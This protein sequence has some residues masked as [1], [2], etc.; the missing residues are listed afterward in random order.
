MTNT[1]STN[2]FTDQEQFMTAGNQTVGAY[3]EE[4]EE[5]YV[6]LITEEYKEFIDA[7]Q[8]ET[9][10]NQVKEALAPLISRN[11]SSPQRIPD[12]H[13]SWEA[14]HENNMLKVANPPIK[15]A[16]GKIQKSPEAII[17]KVVMIEK[18]IDLTLMHH[19]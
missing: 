16:S 1:T 8:N 3:N 18:L 12:A 4:Q 14:V 9:L 10:E 17:G 6:K 7:V 13:K 15:D 2:I 11:V 19:D 5:L